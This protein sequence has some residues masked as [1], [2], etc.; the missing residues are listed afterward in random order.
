MSKIEFKIDTAEFDE[1]FKKLVN[2]TIPELQ[3]KGMGVAMLACLGDCIM[4]V[5]TVPVKEGTLRGSGSIFVQNEFIK[6]SSDMPKAKSGNAVRNHVEAKKPH[7]LIGVIGFNTPYAARLHENN[8][9]FTEPSSGPKYL[10]SK[11]LRYGKSYLK[12]I[13]DVIKG[14][15]A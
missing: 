12:E 5:P 9:N 13:A 14:G 7:K 3:E 1:K 8:F 15:K 4:E 6:D 10:E 2:S 11:L